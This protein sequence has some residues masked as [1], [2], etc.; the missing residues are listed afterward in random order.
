MKIAGIDIGK[1]GAAALITSRRLLAPRFEVVDL[2]FNDKELNYR[3]YRDLLRSWQ[4]DWIYIEN[5]WAIPR[6]PFGN[7]KLQGQGIAQAGRF[8]QTIGAIKAI[9]ACEVELGHCI[10]V[11]PQRWKKLFGLQN[12]DD[13][14]NAARAILA[15]L[16][17]EAAPYVRRV[18]DDGKAEAGLVALY[19]AVGQGV[20]RLESQGRTES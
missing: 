14:K 20:L 8:S 15:S 2:P 1:K 7:S 10:L 11:T 16:I 9:S 13:A 6:N 17:T 4:P 19:G 18:K 3:A 12:H 5:V